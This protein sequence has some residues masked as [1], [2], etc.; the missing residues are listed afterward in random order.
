MAR[1]PKPRSSCAAASRSSSPASRIPRRSKPRPKTFRS[2]SSIEDADLAV[3]NKPAGMMV[4]AGSGQNEDARSR[5]TLVNA[6]LHRFQG[7][8]VHRRRPAPRHRAS[9]RQ[10]HQRPDHRGQKRPRPRRAGRNVLQPPD[11]QD[12]HRAGAGRGRAREGNHQRRR[13]PRPR[14][15]HAHDHAA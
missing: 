1:R 13:R 6:L 5:G 7:A 14:A 9:A 11:Q 10:R 15:P 8:L 12:L 3:V 4:H 2:T